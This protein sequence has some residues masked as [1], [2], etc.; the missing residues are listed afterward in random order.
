MPTVKLVT[1]KSWTEGG[2][3]R[4]LEF[5]PNITRNA[6]VSDSMRKMDD[7]CPVLLAKEVTNAVVVKLGLID[8]GEYSTL[9]NNCRVGAS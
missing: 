9:T 3:H 2:Y 7:V 5:D 8:M 4:A 1:A 6:E